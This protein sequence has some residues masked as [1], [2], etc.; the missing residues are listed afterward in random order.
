VR[1]SRALA[2]ALAV[3]VAASLAACESSQDRSAELAK[4]GATAL[5]EAPGLKVGKTSTTVKV[6]GSPTIL[7]SKAGTAVVV[8]LQNTGS[9]PLEDVPI[10]I[11]VLDKKGKKLFTNTTPGLQKSLQSMPVLE[12]GKPEDWV[13]DQIFVS[14]KPAK[15]TVKVGSSSKQLD[16][17]D[18]PAGLEVSPAKL[19]AAASSGAIGPEANGTLTNKTSA[20]IEQVLLYGVARKGGK[21]VAAGRGGVKKVRTGGK[22]ANYHIFFKGDPRGA[23]ITVTAF[24]N[25]LE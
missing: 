14:G 9:Q 19:S 7:T 6:V 5:K 11:N 22:P 24:P 2:P 16:S 13:N 23:D 18:D 25:K 1:L 3:G 15:V 21:V 4:H 10:A 12:P 17:K 8:T 20:D